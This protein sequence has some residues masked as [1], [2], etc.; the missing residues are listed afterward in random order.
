MPADVA[1]VVPPMQAESPR[2]RFRKRTRR[3]KADHAAIAYLLLAIVG[4]IVLRA[5]IGSLA[6]L[7]VG[8]MVAIAVLPLTPWLLP[9]LGVFLKEISPYVQSLKLGIVELDLRTLTRRANHR[10]VQ[11]CARHST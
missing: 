4:L 1:F 10:P 7:S 6:F 8:W 11:R 5:F 3:L 2:V 9:R